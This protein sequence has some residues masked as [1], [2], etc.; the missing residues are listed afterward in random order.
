MRSPATTAPRAT[1]NDAPQLDPQALE[2]SK[3]I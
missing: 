1:A 2:Y 3:P